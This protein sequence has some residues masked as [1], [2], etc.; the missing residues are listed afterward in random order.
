MRSMWKGSIS[1]GLV[2]IPVKLYT[3]TEQRDVSFRQVHVKDGGRIHFRRVCSLDGEEVPFADVAKGYELPDGEMV[4]LT[5]DDLAYLPL[6]T[7]RSIEVLNF[8]PADQVDPILWNRSYYVEPEPAGTRAYVL[9]RE[10]LDRTGKL[11]VTKVALRQRESL[12]VLR[13][14]DGLLVLETMLWPDEIRAADFPFLDQDI[15]VRSQELR[16]ATSLVDSMTE[17][18]HPD[19]Y[20]DDY[21]E[22]LEQVIAAKVEG[23]EVT[24]PPEPVAEEE[25]ASLLD[26]LQASLDAATKGRGPAPAKRRTGQAGRKASA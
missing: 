14:H 3:A 12:A 17:D 9:L 6:P 11:A 23:R 1:F 13:S 26:A 15:D 21:R 7:A 2:T 16:M 4:V 8:S 22:A 20:H 19:E 25:P 24:P 10:A 5:D 18:F